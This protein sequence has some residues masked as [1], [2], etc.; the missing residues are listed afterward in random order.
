MIS[1]FFKVFFSGGI[2]RSDFTFWDGNYY[3]GLC[4]WVAWEGEVW[5]FFKV[6]RLGFFLFSKKHF[7]GGVGW[8]GILF[9]SFF[10]S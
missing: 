8:G 4:F 5:F 6:G 2:G 7:F 9:F 3:K 1:L 10:L